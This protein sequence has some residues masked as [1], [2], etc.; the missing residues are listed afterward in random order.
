MF[1][2]RISLS[3]L[4]LSVFLKRFKL[5]LIWCYIT[6][7]NDFAAIFFVMMK[8]YFTRSISLHSCLSQNFKLC[9]TKIMT[10]STYR[11]P[12]LNNSCKTSSSGHANDWRYFLVLLWH[13]MMFWLVL[14]LPSPRIRPIPFR[15]VTVIYAG[16]CRNVLVLFWTSEVQMSYL[17]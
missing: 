2:T 16:S 11:C 1:K 13:T 14:C 17:E 8:I 7:W 10:S 3:T 6:G 15:F 4:F 5:S 12:M 9:S